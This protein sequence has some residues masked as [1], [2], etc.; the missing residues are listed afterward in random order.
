MEFLFGKNNYV[1]A[2]FWCVWEREWERD[3][4]GRERGRDWEW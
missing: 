1:T 4:A 2:A 3:G